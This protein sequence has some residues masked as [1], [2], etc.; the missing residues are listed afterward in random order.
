[1]FCEKCG[2][3]LSDQD[4]W[5][6]KC[7]APVNSGASSN[8]GPTHPIVDGQQS[9]DQSQP[10][11]TENTQLGP[12][13]GTEFNRVFF[14]HPYNNLGGFF[15]FWTY[16]TI[17]F[18]VIGI[19]FSLAN[20]S[21]LIGTGTLI[22]VAVDSI[23]EPLDIVDKIATAEQT[24]DPSIDLSENESYRQYQEIKSVG[25]AAKTFG[26]AGGIALILFGA[27]TCWLGFM[28]AFKVRKRDI[29]FFKWWSAQT[30]VSIAFYIIML[31]FILSLLGNLEQLKT[32]FDS[33]SRS[34]SFKNVREMLSCI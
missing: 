22:G 12:D 30:I 1:M 13:N 32:Q 15:A 16:A 2:N 17:V 20:G 6:A 14:N 4:N 28:F 24:I 27:A 3:Q 11:I 21:G 29:H 10:N 18:A 31:A 8:D 7:G 23:T 26:T 5:C 33:S 9:K 25:D 19:I 34:T